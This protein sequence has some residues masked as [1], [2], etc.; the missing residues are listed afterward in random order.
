MK[1]TKEQEVKIF[2]FENVDHIFDHISENID[3][4]ILKFGHRFLEID[5]YHLRQKMID[6]LFGTKSYDHLKMSKF[7]DIV[8]LRIN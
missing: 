7:S 3:E 4:K 1:Q 6:S 5:S 8:I 2:G